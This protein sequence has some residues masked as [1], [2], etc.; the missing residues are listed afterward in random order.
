MYVCH[1]CGRD[2]SNKSEG[3]LDKYD[4]GGT[5]QEY[6]ENYNDYSVSAPEEMQGN[7]YSNVGRDYSPAWG[8]QFQGGGFLQPTSDK[9]PEGY[10]IPY[11]TPSTELSMSIG[12]EDGEPAYL[13][14]SFKG[15]RKLKDPIAEYKKTGEHLG[16]PFKTW[17]EAEKF[18]EMRHKYVEKGQDIP[19]PIKTWGD[20]AMG[21]SLPG[22]VGFT[23]ARTAGSAPANGKY[24]KKTKA[25][26]QKGKSIFKAPDVPAYAQGREST[27]TQQ[28]TIPLSDVDISRN[29]FRNETLR[30]KDNKSFTLNPVKLLAR[31]ELSDLGENIDPFEY[32]NKEGSPVE[33]ILRS[34]ILGSK[35]KGR[36][37]LEEAVKNKPS[38][39]DPSYIDE[40]KTRTDLLQLY[41]RRPQQYNTLEP[42][43]YIPTSGHQRGDEYVK[44]KFVEN[45]LMSS[46]L[47]QSDTTQPIPNLRTKEDIQRYIETHGETALDTKPGAKTRGIPTKVPALGTATLSAGEENGRP[48]LSYYDL[49]DLNP[50]VGA[51]SSVPEKQQQNWHNQWKKEGVD[52]ATKFAG[53]KPPKV[54]GRI[55]FD[56]ETGRPIQKEDGGEIPHA[57]NGQEMSYYQHGLD[58]KTKGMKNG[59]WL[60]AYDLPQAQEGDVFPKREQPTPASESTSI[61]RNIPGEGL[62]TTATT[63]QRKGDVKLDADAMKR[64]KAAETKD[65]QKR[66]AERK[67]AI[68]AKDKGKPFTLPTGESKKYEDMDWREKAYVSGK[69]LESKGRANEDD[70]AWYDDINPINWVTDM[71]G[72][73]ATAPYEARESNSNM[74]YLSAIATPLIEGALGFDPLGGA[75]KVPGR[76]VQSME[77]G[78]LSN[79]DKLNPYA[80]KANPEAYYRGIGKAGFD[81]ASQTGVFRQA[82]VESGVPKYNEVWYATGNKGFGRA[83]GFSE[84]YI[85]EVPESAFSN[86]SLDKFRG[87][88]GM[89]TRGTLEKIPIDKG[90]ILQKHWLGYKEVPK[91]TSSFKSEIDWGNWNKEISEDLPLMN[92]YNAIEQTSKANGSWMKNPDGS[93]FEGTPEQFVQQNS[94]NFKNAFG[95]SKLVNPD[96][97]PTIQYHG[98]AKNFDTF[99]ESKFQLGDAG[100]S[101][102][103]IYTTPDKSKASSYALSSKSIHKG[104]YDPTVYELYGQGNNPISAENLIKQNK[105]Y[106]LFNFHREKNWQGDVPLE[107][108]MLDHDVAIRNQTRGIERVSPWNQAAELVFPTNKQLKSATG[109]NGMF[110]MTNPNIYKALVPAAIGAGALEQKKEGGVVKDDMGYWNPDNH[111]KVVEI[112]SPY[113]TM[114][115][116]DEPLIGISD[117]GDKK[118]MLPGKN[119]KFKGKKVREYPVA[120][121][122]VRQ[123]QKGLLNLDQLT[124]FTNYNKPQPGGW[125]DKY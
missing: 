82:G 104:D 30:A 116:V 96:G 117:E 120:K 43:D 44:S 118:Y 49:W 28:P 16:G 54:Y 55:Y 69:S 80:F 90:R 93:T 4:D 20:M 115:G 74:P 111:G 65:K 110:D 67:S 53:A 45:A 12:G 87:S 68:A 42:A 47:N 57:Q 105:D 7:G 29:K 60:D 108:Q 19:S 85:A 32:G 2:N 63:G 99:D 13:I 119:Y 10:V 51:Y 95:N 21:G 33:R 37:N 41:A 121:N 38:D 113:I 107:Q 125:L 106:D 89:Q 100:Y 112:G 124:N 91:P 64:F 83:K 79:A 52:I 71:A 26:A 114:E 22:T 58:F 77:S 46:I 94:E 92:E 61:M 81:D 48:Y 14:P 123:E 3:W 102:K 72:G 56:P 36:K 35:E 5:M 39:I 17:Q 66:I 122:G 15:G 1:Q 34:G 103:G 109:N 76:V 6:Q 84:D 70:E 101:G 88:P 11:N 27:A 18:G 40:G 25:S 75:M 31:Q 73:L 86:A 97:S 59:G 50:F 8:G 62:S 9:L 98:S 78:V 24:T 23:Y